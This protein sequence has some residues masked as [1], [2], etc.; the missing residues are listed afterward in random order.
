MKKRSAIIVAIVFMMIGFAAVSTSLIINSNIKVSK[1]ETDF[2]VYFSK[3]RLD[4]KD[5]YES[6]ISQDKKTII[7]NTNNLSKVGDKQY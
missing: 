6:V 5:V 1:N 2:D 7:F 3:A 4:T